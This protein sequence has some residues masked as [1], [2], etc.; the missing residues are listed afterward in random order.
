MPKHPYPKELEE[1]CT[2]PDGRVMKFRNVPR[3]EE[4]KY[5]AL[6]W[7]GTIYRRSMPSSPNP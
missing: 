4:E 7:K 3:T 1:L 2:L 5:M 6:T